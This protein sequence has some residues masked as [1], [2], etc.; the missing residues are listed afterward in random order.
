MAVIREERWLVIP[1][2]CIVITVS[3]GVMNLILAVIVQRAAEAREMDMEV[4]HA[5]EK[6][7]RTR[8]KLELL[9][10]CAL[11]DDDESGAVSLDELL[12]AYDALPSFEQRM[13]IMGVTRS[14]LQT[15]F[16]V[17]D[18]DDSGEVG[19]LEFVDNIYGVDHKND[20]LLVSTFQLAA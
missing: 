15:L 13:K 11:S 1:L 10:L 7:A 17:L 9:S 8:E 19:Y 14:D 3:L 6:R 12:A 4:K 18:E 5:E 2:F 20:S 16:E